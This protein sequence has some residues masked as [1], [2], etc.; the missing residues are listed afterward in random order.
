[1][2]VM[3]GGLATF[4]INILHKP[5]VQ[6]SKT[7]P[8]ATQKRAAASQMPVVAQKAEAKATA[9]SGPKT[10]SKRKGKK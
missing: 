10:P 5:T 4:L 9:T 7:N 1:M 8:G 6:G 3:S 2:Y